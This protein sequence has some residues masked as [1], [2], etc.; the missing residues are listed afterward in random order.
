MAQKYIVVAVVAVVAVVVVA[1]QTNQKTL[2]L[3]LETIKIQNICKE[4]FLV[5]SQA[6]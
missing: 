6:I 3:M 2:L 1:V 4:T 5:L